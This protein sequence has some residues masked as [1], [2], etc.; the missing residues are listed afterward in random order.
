MGWYNMKFENSNK[1]K[2]Y[3]SEETKKLKIHSNNIY[4]MYFIRNF[5]EKIQSNN[6]DLY[7][8]KGSLS[9]YANTKDLIRP[10]TDL[11]AVS[12]LSLTDASYELEKIINNDDTQIK[13]KLKEKFITTRD[14]ASIKIMCNF[15]LI[16]QMI[17]IDLKHEESAHF[18]SATIPK[19][20]T[21][22]EPFKA[23][24]IGIEQN[25]ANKIYVVIKSL[26]DYTNFKKEI[27][28]WKD[29][30]DLYQ[31]INTNKYNIKLVEKFFIESLKKYGYID[32][33]NI[34]WNILGQ[35]EQIYYENAKQNQYM[36]ETTFNQVVD[37]SKNFVDEIKNKGI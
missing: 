32:I 17:Q 30:Y 34:N 9:Q 33:S 36:K 35:F 13:Y 22:D 19:I 3:L 12:N 20:F 18:I 23:N 16:S 4:T 6:P 28:R 15:D 31:L 26:Y 8:V 37:T 21:K 10:I 27:R 29:F 1:L 5:L 25:I 14:T 2:G 24:I 7:V 11:D